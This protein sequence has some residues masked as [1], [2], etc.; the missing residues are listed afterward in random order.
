MSAETRPTQSPSS[1]LGKN[2]PDL[3]D[4]IRESLN[5]LIDY[6]WDDELNDFRAAMTDKRASEN[7]AD[8]GGDHIFRHLV[9][10]KAW[11]EARHLQPESYIEDSEL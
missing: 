10:L 11:I 9:S 5:H 4:H 3:P 2:P 6:L 7:P 1:D 8:A